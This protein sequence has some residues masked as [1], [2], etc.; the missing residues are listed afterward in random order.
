QQATINDGRVNLQP[1][2]WRQIYFATGTS[3]TYTPAAS[4]SNSGKQ[5]IIICYNCKGEGHMS[6]QCT[7]PKRKWDDSW[8]KDKVLLTVITENVA[9]QTDDLDAYDSDCDELNTTKVALMAN[10]SHYVS[11]ALVEVHNPD[12]KDNNMINQVIVLKND[13]KQEESRNIDREIALETKIKLLDNIVYKKDQ[14]V[15]PL[16]MLT[17]PRFFYDHSTKQ[18]LG[19]QNPFYLKKAQQLEPKLYDALRDELRKLKGKAVVD[20]AVRSQTIS[21]EML[22]INVEPIAPKLLNNRTIHSDYLRHT[23]EQAVILREVYSKLNANSELIFVKCNGYM[24]FDNHDL[25]VLNVINDVNAR[26]RS[27]SKKTSK[28]KV[29]KPTGKVFTKIRYTWKPNGRT[30]DIVG[31]ACPLTRI[32]EPT[33]E[34]PRKP[35]VLK[36]DTPK[37]VV[38]LVYS[39]KP[40][41]SKTNVPISKPK[42]IKSVSAN[43]K[44]PNKS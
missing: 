31:N 20:N 36:N 15:Q 41:K 17:K 42:I 40:R 43:N 7:K 2:Q 32:T 1:V 30:F 12:N 34:P 16:H 6:K 23:Q 29:W 8:F 18:A 33:E 3:K 14:S 9:Y 35:T 13:L 38:T 10:L 22:T 44:E 4:G 28:R 26:H 19:F 24:R 37:P 11:D 25:C 39:R 21:P 27:K 5:M